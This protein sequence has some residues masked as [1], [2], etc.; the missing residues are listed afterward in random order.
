MR[1]AEAS[2]LKSILKD[3]GSD[4]LA[5]IVDSKAAQHLSLP[6]LSW[7]AFSTGS[8]QNSGVI[9]MLRA[10]G[11]PESKKLAEWLEP[12]T[13]APPPAKRGRDGGDERMPRRS[14]RHKSEPGG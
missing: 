1:Q 6:S 13:R 2:E 4:V 10:N 9:H 14:P 12:Y 7:G 11:G 5:R 3:H 8:A